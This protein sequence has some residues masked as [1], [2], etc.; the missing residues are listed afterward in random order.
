MSAD[1]RSA[2][3]PIDRFP[4]ARA[5]KVRAI[6]T[7]IDDTLTHNGRLPAAAYAALEALRD[8]GFIVIPVTG[9]PAG[10]CDLIAR[11]WPVSGVVGEN[12]AF[13]FRYD[14]ENRRMIRRYAKTA[15]QR[16]TDKTLLEAIRKEVLRDVEGCCG[17]IGP[18]VP[19]GR[20]RHRLL[21]GRRPAHRPT[22]S[23]I[24]SRSLPSTGRRRRSHRST[25]TAGSAAT[26]S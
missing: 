16:A 15:E 5:A 25:S 3:A 12:G 17:G 11:Q 6:L 10:W 18:G 19:G 24:S 13:Y 22:R 2:F 21:R 20:S 1:N 14:D 8:A 7:D 9:R 23:M 4:A 26:T